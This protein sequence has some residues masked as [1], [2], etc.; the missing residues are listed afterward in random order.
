VLDE[1][2]IHQR[3]GR[4]QGLWH[5]ACCGLVSQARPENGSTQRCP[6]CLMALHERKPDSLQRTWAYLS[7]AVLLYI[8]ANVLPVMGTDSV[9]GKFEHTILGGIVELWHAQS[10]ELA[11]IVFIASIAVP[12]MKMAALGL[13]AA[14]AQAG[15]HWRQ[16]ERARLYRLLESVGHW[17]MLDVFVVVSLVG[18]VQFGALASVR[19]ETG[20]LAFGGVVIATMLASSSFDARLLWPEGPPSTSAHTWLRRLTRWGF[21]ERRTFHKAANHG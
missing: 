14:T 2:R 19:P 1:A 13:L 17:S 4:A 11:I 6:R 9:L 20:L 18:M 10:Y 16:L 7:A 5:C 3:T 12:I 15:S 21:L 8:P